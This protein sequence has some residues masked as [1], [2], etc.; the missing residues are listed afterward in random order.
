M[1]QLLQLTKTLDIALGADGTPVWVDFDDSQAHPAETVAEHLAAPAAPHVVATTPAA[2]VPATGAAG[3]AVPG[4]GYLAQ[5][6]PHRWAA[7]VD[8]DTVAAVALAHGGRVANLREVL[9]TQGDCPDLL[10]AA[11]YV[12]NQ[13]AHRFH[14]GDGTPLTFDEQGRV[15]TSEFGAPFFPRLD[16]AVIGLVECAGRVLVGR[17]RMRPDFFSLIAGYVSPGETLE[18]A[19]AREVWEETGRRVG[20]VRYLGS[21]P[22]P[23]SG[24]LMLGMYGVTDDVDAVGP[25]D[26]ELIE[27]RWL[28]REEVLSGALPL[29]PPGSIAHQLLDYWAHNTQA[30]TPQKSIFSHD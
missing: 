23:T 4:L 13:E 5:V 16:P 10:A 25:C 27:V 9:G 11:G 1:A 3:T 30:F 21:Q 12:K 15:G 17:N 26:G 14:P 24:A 6:S 19:F 28:R 2:G 7:L 22:W 20:Q 18:A 29:S 8:E